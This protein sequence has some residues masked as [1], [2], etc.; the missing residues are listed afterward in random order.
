MNKIGQRHPSINDEQRA[1]QTSLFIRHNSARIASRYVVEVV[2]KLCVKKVKEDSSISKLSNGFYL[3]TT[4]YNRVREIT[5]TGHHIVSYDTL[6]YELFK[7]DNL[8]EALILKEAMRLNGITSRAVMYRMLILLIEWV[9]TNISN[10]GLIPKEVL[11]NTILDGHYSTENILQD[12]KVTKERIVRCLRQ[13]DELLITYHVL[14]F[15]GCFSG[16]IALVHSFRFPIITSQ[17]GQARSYRYAWKVMMTLKLITL[18]KLITLLMS[19]S[20]KG[21]GLYWFAKCALDPLF[22]SRYKKCLR[23]DKVD[24]QLVIIT[25]LYLNLEDK[26]LIEDGSIVMNHP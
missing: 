1:S 18:H 19:D 21:Q 22:S 11:Y 20:H 8:D 9:F 2:D 23:I 24:W 26:V 25:I 10:N 15:W 13:I 3:E 12:I 4:Q 16:K 5:S 6:I 17:R 7:N 14:L